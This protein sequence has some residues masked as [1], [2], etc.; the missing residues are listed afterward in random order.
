MTCECFSRNALVRGPTK[1]PEPGAGSA[2]ENAR[3]VRR[4]RNLLVARRRSL[5]ISAETPAPLSLRQ[6]GRTAGAVG[7]GDE[8]LT[9]LRGGSPAWEFDETGGRGRCGKAIVDHDPD[10]NSPGV[11]EH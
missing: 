5:K 3:G 9:A 2:C 7:D 4:V 6:S 1:R 8:A 11:S 10:V